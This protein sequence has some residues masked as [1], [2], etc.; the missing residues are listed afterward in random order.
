M[1]LLQVTAV[2]LILG[3]VI[4]TSGLLLLEGFWDICEIVGA[5][6]L[7]TFGGVVVV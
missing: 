7:E 5:S 4:D 1:V 6:V 2:V 3:L